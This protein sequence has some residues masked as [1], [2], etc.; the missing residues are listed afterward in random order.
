LITS[1]LGNMA[2]EQSTYEFL[3]KYQEQHVFIVPKE[4]ML[5]APLP[6][7]AKVAAYQGEIRA[8]E[9]APLKVGDTVRL[10]T[11]P[12]P[13]EVMTVKQIGAPTQVEGSRLKIA[14]CLLEGTGGD[15][16]KTPVTN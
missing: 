4:K 2:M 10:L 1:G 9:Y 8:E 3:E 5:V 13:G 16:I 14:H 7:E 6:A 15:T 11:S 12:S